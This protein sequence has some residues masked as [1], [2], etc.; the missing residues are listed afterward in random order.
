MIFGFSWWKVIGVLAIV[1]V[2]VAFLFPGSSEAT[3]SNECE[4]E[5]ISEVVGTEYEVQKQVF[6]LNPFGWHD[7]GDSFWTD[8]VPEEGFG[9]RYIVV[10]ERDI[11]EEVVNPE[12]DPNCG[13]YV[14]VVWRAPVDSQSYID[15]GSP[16]G[17]SAD[18]IWPQSYV[19][20]V[21]TD[22]KDVNA[23]DSY[24]TDECSLV[25]QVDVYPYAQG[26]ATFED[27]TL[28]AGEDSGFVKKWKMVVNDPC[29]EPTPTPTVQPTPEPTR[30]P[31]PE[32]ETMR[33]CLE[34][35][36]VTIEV[37]DY[38]GR[39]HDR[40]I[41]G[42]CDYVPPVIETPVPTFTF[43]VNGDEV[44][45]T[46]VQ[47][48]AAMASGFAGYPGECV[49]QPTVGEPLPPQT[50]PDFPLPAKAGHGVFD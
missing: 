43:C 46:L 1:A 28:T 20:Y 37:D 34:G 45:L 39:I 8:E 23:A 40:I 21:Q 19:G 33:V 3:N 10:D 49:T 27:G 9:Y 48:D 6:K 26:V 7:K 22:S 47:F 11:T 18:I 30:E 29:V 24:L 5:F 38:D 14:T 16:T 36:K 12:Y 13:T 35:M 41:N 25:Y 4:P 2:A 15:A 42:V 32:P 50:V 44:E 31:E 17:P